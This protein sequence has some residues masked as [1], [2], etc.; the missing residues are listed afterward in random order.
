M[1]GSPFVDKD[2]NETRETVKEKR[3]KEIPIIEKNTE[4]VEQFLEIKYKEAINYMIQ[5]DYTEAVKIQTEN[6]VKDMNFIK[7]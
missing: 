2:W 6:Q 1:A 7:M 5:R 3:V 4:T